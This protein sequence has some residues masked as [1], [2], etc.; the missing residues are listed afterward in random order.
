MESEKTLDVLALGFLERLP[1]RIRAICAQSA[2][3]GPASWQPGPVQELCR[4]LHSL[5]G[6][7]GTFGQPALGKKARCLLD[8]V[9]GWSFEG[10]TQAEWA[11]WVGMLGALKDVPLNSPHQRY[12]YGGTLADLGLERTA[13]RPLDAFDIAK[14]CIHVLE[15][16]VEQAAMLRALLETHGYDVSV[17]EE[18]ATFRDAWLAGQRADLVLA[19]MVF[20]ERLQAGAEAVVELLATVECSPPVVFLSAR[21]DIAARLAAFRA[22]ASRYLTKPVQP[23]RLFELVDELSLRRPAEPYRVMVVDDDEDQAALTARPLRGA[24][25]SVEIV[26]QPLDTLDTLR[27]FSPDLLLLNMSMKQA[28][29]PEIA[30]ILREEDQ[31]AFLPILFMSAEKSEAEQLMALSMGGDDFLHKPIRAVAL[32]AAVRARAWRARR[33]RLLGAHYQALAY[34]HERLLDGMARGVALACADGKGNLTSVN[35]RLRALLGYDDANDQ[36]FTG[37]SELSQRLHDPITM[38]LAV[39][40]TWH[41]EVLLPHRDG[42]NIAVATTITPFSNASGKSCKALVIVQPK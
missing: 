28:S 9:E 34:E 11:V 17:F 15:D 37:M 1:A 40:E 31:F 6:A 39:D 23:S 2:R 14:P 26:N 12:G 36:H 7:A 25:M 30:A 32:L 19:D 16:D 33:M 24:G 42:R 4:L 22:G 13:S 38:C 5:V 41:G 18:T 21:D 27:S 35:A 10:P 29:G 8:F 3:L 20:A